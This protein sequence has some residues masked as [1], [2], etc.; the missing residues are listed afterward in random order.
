RAPVLK[1]STWLRRPRKNVARPCDRHRHFPVAAPACDRPDRLYLVERSG[2][3]ANA[4]NS[5]AYYRRGN[6]KGKEGEQATGEKAC[7]ETCGKAATQTGKKART[8]A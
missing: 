6:G 3:V 7:T 8:Q 4:E 2:A 1:R 5:A